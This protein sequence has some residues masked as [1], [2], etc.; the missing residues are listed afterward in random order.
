ME[1]TTHTVAEAVPAE[2]AIGE[3]AAVS[4]NEGLRNEV[5]AA[6]SEI[7]DPEIPVNIYELGL[8]YDVHVGE[9]GKVDLVMTLT[10]PHCPVAEILP[11]QVKTRVELVEG[12]NK[13]ELELTWEPPWTP[14]NMSEAAKLELGFM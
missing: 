14:E 1:D 11:G 3:N 4:P 13:V 2:D 12:V 8:I 9:E 7:F 10:S 5:I 6:I